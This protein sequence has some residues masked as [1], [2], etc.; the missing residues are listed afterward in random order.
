MLILL[1]F[2]KA[3]TQNALLLGTIALFQPS[4]LNR[5][6]SLNYQQNLQSF[7]GK[8]SSVSGISIP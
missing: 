5:S 7:L 3:I 6:L 2:T 4:T 8:K 1:V